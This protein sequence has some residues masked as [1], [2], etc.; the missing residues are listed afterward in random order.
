MRIAVVERDVCNPKKCEWLCQRV[1]P[2]NRTGK[3]CIKQGE[4]G[5]PVIDEELC[6]G[7]G[8]CVRKCPFSALSVVNLPQAKEEPVHRYLPNGFCLFG[9]P[10]L[11]PNQV[12]GL[13]GPNGIGKTTILNLLSGQLKPNLGKP[14]ATWEEVLE[15]FKGTQLKPYL[16]KLAE[17]K[18]RLAYKP[19]KVDL[20]P[21]YWKG[22]VGKYIRNKDLLKRLGLRP[23]KQIEGLSGG[24]L[25]LL[26]IAACL[27][28]DAEFYFFDEPSSFLDVEKRFRV[29]KLIR[30]LAERKWVVIVEHDL[31]LLDYLADTVCILYG[32]PGSFGIC[33]R[34]YG[35]RAGINSWLSGYLKDANVRIREE[36]ITFEVY[37]KESLKA[38]VLL[39]YPEF[40]FS[41][42]G[43]Q[44]ETQAGDIKAGEVIGI[45]GPNA[46]GKTTFIRLLA[47]ELEPD[48]KPG[49]RLAYKP[50]LLKAGPER[51]RDFLPDL[52]LLGY[53]GLETLAERRLEDLSGGELQAI[54][55]LH[56]L[57]TDSELMLLDEPSAFLDAEL[58]LRIAKLIRQKVEE[59]GTAGFVVDHDLLFLDAI[60]DRLIVFSGEPGRNGRASQPLK[61]KEGMNLFLKGMGITFRRDPE[62][63]RPR[64]NKPGSQLDRE[65]RERG[66]YYYSK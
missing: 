29:A 17:G 9:L 16:E 26:A 33:S 8:I 43:F 46:T 40:K 38:E 45:L 39:E 27:Q 7:C 2:V 19:Q 21:K 65:Q 5:K 28:K 34:P 14:E 66:E 3:E 54:Y 53:L 11:Q 55:T 37:A 44:L 22:E 31:A 25:Q 18:I 63:G 42:D 15:R 64:A 10:L 60:S 49:L 20:I 1:C 13:L 52:K 51:V 24:E 48:W 12:L 56:T 47:G 35:V 58:R 23:E 57:Q 32:R 30:E 36:A 62:T 59:K 6:V 61:L 41:W 4:D 50:Q